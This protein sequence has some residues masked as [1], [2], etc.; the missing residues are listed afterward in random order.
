MRLGRKLKT[1]AFTSLASLSLGAHAGALDAFSNADASTGLKQALDQGVSTAVA[2]LGGKNGFLDS[3]R[4][5]IP[6]PDAIK[7]TE[8][9]LRMMG[10]GAALDELDVGLNRA[11]EQAVAMATP[12]LTKAVKSM[13]VNDAKNIVSGPDDSVTQYFRSKTSAELTAQFLPIVAKITG[14][15][16]LAEQYNTLAGGGASFGLIKKEDANIDSYVTR[17]AL[18]ALYTRIGDEERAIRANPAAAVGKYA[19][20]VFGALGK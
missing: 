20:Q 5:R 4:F 17:L 6:L 14:K 13:S 19:N 10:K 2:S 8:P 12:L 11:A 3:A 1:I 7:Q 16:Q 9:A 15:M 18:D